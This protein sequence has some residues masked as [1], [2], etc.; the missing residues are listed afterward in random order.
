MEILKVARIENGPHFSDE[1]N[2]LELT[3]IND[4]RKAMKKKLTIFLSEEIYLATKA[5]RITRYCSW[6]E[7]K[8]FESDTKAVYDSPEDNGVLL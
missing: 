3:A 5:E 7:I 8:R 4:A 6:V 2:I 1:T